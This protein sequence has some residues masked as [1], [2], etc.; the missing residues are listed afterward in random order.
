MYVSLWCNHCYS[1]KTIS[2]N[3]SQCVF[4]ALIIQLPMRIRQIVICG[5]SG[6][7]VFFHII[8]QRARISGEKIFEHEMRILIFSTNFVYS[9]SEKN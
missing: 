5:L 9:H 8:S 3:Y 7:T 2:I 1:G 4:V 6:S